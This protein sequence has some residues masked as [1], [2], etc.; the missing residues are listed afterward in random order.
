[1]LRHTALM[2]VVTLILSPGRLLVCGWDC[3]DELPI[4][5]E[6]SCHQPSAA[7]EAVLNAGGAHPCPPE[8][9][10]TPVTI[11]Q[12][13]GLAFDTSA[14]GGTQTATF[15]PAI[16]RSAQSQRPPSRSPLTRA[17]CTNVLRI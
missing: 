11:S 10:E 14:D 1:M 5:A 17:R 4:A 3:L 13:S 15:A 12:K 7:P 2:L 8:A 6:A 9:V 16:A